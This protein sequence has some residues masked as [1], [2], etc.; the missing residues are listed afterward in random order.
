MA[1]TIKFIVALLIAIN[2]LA[3]IGWIKIN[4]PELEHIYRLFIKAISL[5][6]DPFF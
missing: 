5:I 1:R 4:H 3:E 2:I 6:L